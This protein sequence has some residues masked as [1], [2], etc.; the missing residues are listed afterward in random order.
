MRYR[1]LAALALLIANHCFAIGAVQGKVIQVRV[2]QSGL[3]MV[4]FDQNVVGAFAACRDSTNYFNALSFNVNNAGGKAILATALAAKASGTTI[5]AY[6]DGSCSN[7]GAYVEN[8]SYGIV[9]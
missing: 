3:G 2:D 5:Q 4:I 8:W 6:G 9:L 7:Y 1:I